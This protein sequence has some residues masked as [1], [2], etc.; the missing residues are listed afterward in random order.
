MNKTSLIILILVAAS[1]LFFIFQFTSNQSL[2]QSISDFF[3]VDI[4]D[5]D[6]RLID[7]EKACRAD[8]ITIRHQNP[9][10]GEPTV[11]AEGDNEK[12]CRQKLVNKIY[13]LANE[14]CKLYSKVKNKEKQCEAHRGNLNVTDDISYDQNRGRCQLDKDVKYTCN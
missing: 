12:E 1:V 13:D 5:I 4:R 10:T 7:V 14:E 11:T 2:A 8:E 6:S 3:V 9:R